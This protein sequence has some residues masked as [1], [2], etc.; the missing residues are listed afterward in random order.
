MPAVSATLED[1][2]ETIQRL[3]QAKG[4]AR[5]RDIAAELAVHKSTVTAALRSLATKGLVTYS[6]YEIARLTAAG[7]SMAAEIAHKHYGIRK[8]L[9]DVLM[10]DA[11]AADRNACRMEHVMDREVTERLAAFAQLVDR[12]AV[13][14]HFKRHLAGSKK[15][16]K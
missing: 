6:P 9:T 4:V 3:E 15:R 7:Q 13:S 2:L 1:Y 12:K 8:F 11:K 14:K 10:I 5:V 16:T